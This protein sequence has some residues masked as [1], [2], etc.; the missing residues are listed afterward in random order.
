MKTKTQVSSTFSQYP[1]QVPEQTRKLFL[2]QFGGKQT[3]LY[4]EFYII[5]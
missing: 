1:M 2:F 3:I 5:C 4:Q